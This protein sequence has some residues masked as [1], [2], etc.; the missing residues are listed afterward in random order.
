MLIGTICGGI[1]S[2]FYKFYKINYDIKIEDIHNISIQQQISSLLQVANA[3]LTGCLKGCLIFI[4]FLNN[5][6]IICFPLILYL[7]I[8]MLY[9]CYSIT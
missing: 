6:I 1:C 5:I 9:I 3:T 2:G 8:H 7:T 4:M